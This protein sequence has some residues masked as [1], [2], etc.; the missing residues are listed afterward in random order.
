[1]EEYELSDCVGIN[2][3]RIV[4]PCKHSRGICRVAR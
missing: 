2:C 1:M 3:K 4:N